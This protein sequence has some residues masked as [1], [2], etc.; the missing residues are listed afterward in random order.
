VQ[1]KT[2][3]LV[4]DRPQPSDF[5]QAFPRVQKRTDRAGVIEALQAG[6]SLLV[7]D[8]Y[9]TGLSIL[10][11]L[12]A[13]LKKLHPDDDF[14]GNRAFRSAYQA[15]AQRLFAPIKGHALALLKAPSIGWL[16]R[17]YPEL[18]EFLLPFPKIQGL[19]SAWQ[20][21]QKGIQLPVLQHKL[22][23]FYGTY[24][25]TRHDHIHLFEDWL[26]RYSG[27]FE[28]VID[29]GTGCGVLSFQLLNHGSQEV[30]ATDINP[31]AI[32][33][34]Q[35]DLAQL[36]MTGKIHLEHGDLFGR[37]SQKFDL[38]VFN[39]PWLPG[40]THGE[41]D[42]AIYYPPDLFE[43]FFEQAA[44]RLKP[45]GHMVLLFSNLAQSSGL[46]TEHPVEIELVEGGR[47]R[48]VDRLRRKVQAAS[49]KTK[50]SGKSRDKEFVELWAL[51]LA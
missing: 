12:K 50:R 29:V 48:K 22:H 3:N 40:A 19:N 4:L 35:E 24:F 26:S 7:T 45:S 51:A 6:E 47:F 14:Q 20:W 2:P 11:D 43:R 28:N 34:V 32:K 1:T 16:A 39:P 37:Y 30:W 23:P 44:T 10:A 17:L 42:K 5:E 41:L 33:S 9:S 8:V 18:D 13:H 27:S 25:P 36:N 49:S 21:H 15:C 31:N 46:T 38:I